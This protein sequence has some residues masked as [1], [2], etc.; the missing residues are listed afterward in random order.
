MRGASEI[1]NVSLTAENAEGA[2]KSPINCPSAF[3]AISAVNDYKGTPHMTHD[4]PSR[5]L[6]EL[7][8]MLFPYIVL[9][10]L[11]S[12]LFANQIDNVFVACLLFVGMVGSAFFGFRKR[13][14][15]IEKSVREQ[16]E[17]LLELTGLVN[18]E[19]E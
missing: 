12:A 19:E 3:S 2:E 8:T 4:P 18:E 11:L 16:E 13:Y 17:K 14:E 10:P 7:K 1:Q 9:G 5:Q 6:D 15:M